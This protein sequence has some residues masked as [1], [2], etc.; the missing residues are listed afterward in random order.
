[1][2][3]SEPSVH[4]VTTQHQ[5]VWHPA[6]GKPGKYGLSPP[7]PIRGTLKLQD[8]G[9]RFRL[10]WILLW[11]FRHV[12]WVNGLSMAGVL[13]ELIARYC[14]AME[15]DERSKSADER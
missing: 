4:S 9:M 12:C 7:R 5:S 3:D 8:T 13:R 6:L 10:S 1:M 2:H 11:R 15:S 14:A